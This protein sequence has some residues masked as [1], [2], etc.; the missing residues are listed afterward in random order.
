MNKKIITILIIL[1]LL[2]VA[3]F[4][5]VSNSN[6][7]DMPTL[8]EMQEYEELAFPNNALDTSDWQVYRNDKFGFEVRYPRD[9]EVKDFS[10]FDGYDRRIAFHPPWGEGADEGVW[11]LAYED[12]LENTYD[13]IISRAPSI[14]YTKKISYVNN[15][16][17][18]QFFGTL[19]FEDKLFN[20]KTYVISNENKTFEFN[21][22]PSG[23]FQQELEQ[24]LLSFKF[25][26]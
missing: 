15:A 22:L 8:V 6:D 24:I 25:T 2:G 13:R 21:D 26:E 20:F 1:A 19:L 11:F 7:K 5:Y 9:W 12:S 10:K 14:N 17:I 18:T 4:A 16:I 3:V 23:Y